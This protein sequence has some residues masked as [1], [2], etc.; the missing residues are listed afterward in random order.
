V[1]QPFLEW[2]GGPGGGEGPRPPQL[3][4]C[5]E[6]PPPGQSHPMSLWPD[7]DQ[8]PIPLTLPVWATAT[9]RK[10]S[11]LQDLVPVPACFVAGGLLAIWWAEVIKAW[12][13]AMCSWA[14]GE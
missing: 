4:R 11:C 2:A 14:W 13:V 12:P 8:T 5:W 9:A 10:S 6:A 3:P 1:L 7:L